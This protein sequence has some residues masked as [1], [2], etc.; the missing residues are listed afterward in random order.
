MRAC[1]FSAAALGVL[2]SVIIGTLEAIAS[3][4]AITL[5]PAFRSWG[6]TTIIVAVVAA[7]ALA[8]IERQ[9]RILARLD[10]I[11]PRRAKSQARREFDAIQKRMRTT[12]EGGSNITSL[13]PEE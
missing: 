13:F 2:L 1:R 11:E 4:S 3:T 6:L 10:E 9:S 12:D 5:V 7:A 8:I